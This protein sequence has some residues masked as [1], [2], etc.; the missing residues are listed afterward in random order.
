MKISVFLKVIFLVCV[1]FGF[2][3]SDLIVFVYRCDFPEY[4]PDFI[5]FPFI[6]R[7]SI[8]WVNSLSANLYLSGL[9]G[10]VLFW[11][12]FAFILITLAE[13][14]ATN[15]IRIAS[16]IAVKSIFTAVLLLGALKYSATEW[17]SK[18][19]HKNFS[20][21]YFKEGV[22]CSKALLFLPDY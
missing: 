9:I 8:P 4:G 6:Y 3:F 19:S 7:S 5:G 10:N 14:V 13:K 18:K 21:G 11:T 20:M 2:A 17:T 22:S 12:I 16:R 1:G 15:G